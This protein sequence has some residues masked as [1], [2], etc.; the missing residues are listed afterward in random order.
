[1]QSA[2][3]PGLDGALDREENA[4]RICFGDFAAS[5]PAPTLIERIAGSGLLA[6]VDLP[7]LAAF[8]AIF[9]ALSLGVA[10]Y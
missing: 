2:R 4:A 3:L 1:M 5:E 8:G 7:R 10:L 9:T 6:G